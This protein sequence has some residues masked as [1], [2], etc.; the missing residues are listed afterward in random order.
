[1][2][3]EQG[4][5]LPTVATEALRL[6]RQPLFHVAWGHKSRHSPFGQPDQLSLHPTTRYKS[7][8]LMLQFGWL[9]KG[10]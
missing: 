5:R 2:R 4:A 9:H 10:A 8:H 7:G 6:M 1:M 3:Q